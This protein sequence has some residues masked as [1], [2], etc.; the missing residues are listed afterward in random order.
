MKPAQ[1]SDYALEKPLKETLMFLQASDSSTGS[2]ILLQIKA[3]P[4]LQHCFKLFNVSV[5]KFRLFLDLLRFC[6]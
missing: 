3:G 6:T 2:D 4:E 1:V 5:S